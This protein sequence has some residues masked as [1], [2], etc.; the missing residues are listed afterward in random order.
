MANEATKKDIV[1]L[2]EEPPEEIVLA[3]KDSEVRIDNFTYLP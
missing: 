1:V 3:P 2:V